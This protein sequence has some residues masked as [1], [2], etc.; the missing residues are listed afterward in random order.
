LNCNER[1]PSQRKREL[2]GERPLPGWIIVLLWK[3][4]VLLRVSQFDRVSEK[5]FAAE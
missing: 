1:R 3:S 2:E 5:R 4:I